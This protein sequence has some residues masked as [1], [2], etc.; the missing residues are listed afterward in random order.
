MRD[1][2]QYALYSL[3][4]SS[5]SLSL[6]LC[7]L[8]V[9]QTASPTNRKFL[10][11]DDER[12][13]TFEAKPQ[14]ERSGIEMSRLYIDVYLIWQEGLDPLVPQKTKCFQATLNTCT[15]RKR[16]GNVRHMPIRSEGLLPALDMLTSTGF[17]P[18][19]ALSS[20][21]ATLPCAEH[22]SC[23]YA[24]LRELFLNAVAGSPQTGEPDDLHPKL[25]MR[26]LWEGALRAL[27]ADGK[28]LP[29]DVAATIVTGLRLSPTD[30]EKSIAQRWKREL[31]AKEEAQMFAE[32][33]YVLNSVSHFPCCVCVCACACA[34]GVWYVHVMWRV[35][36]V[37]VRVRARACTCVCVCAGACACACECVWCTCACVHVRVCR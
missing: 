14:G 24:P 4:P 27:T 30:L 8:P 15:W 6:S 33:K 29:A 3:S 16:D 17:Y 26:Q 11:T 25:R 18:Q 36:C 32:Q 9:F 7:R 1:C 21:P 12:K 20:D 37:C 10:A 23:S 31:R 19:P 5:L 35:S 22:P 28:T 13:A 34:C 2:A